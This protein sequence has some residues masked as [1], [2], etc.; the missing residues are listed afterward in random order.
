M[1]IVRICARVFWGP[2][3]VCLIRPGSALWGWQSRSGV[4]ISREHPTR[5][6]RALF[7]CAG[8][9]PEGGAPRGMYLCRGPRKKPREGF[10]ITAQ[11]AGLAEIAKAHT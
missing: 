9:Y 6:R 5:S 1:R 10:A 7:F 3:E 4:T 11:D 8:P 2:L